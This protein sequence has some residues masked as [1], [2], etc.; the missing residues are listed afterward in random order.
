MGDMADVVRV[1]SHSIVDSRLKDWAR[2]YGGGRYVALGFSTGEHVLAKLIQFGGFLPGSSGPKGMT[3][4]TAADEVE[5]VVKR[6]ASGWPDHAR[7]LRCDYFRPDMAM[8]ARLDLLR[9]AGTKLGRA[10]YY[11]KLESAKLYVAGAL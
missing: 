2:E 8:P 3:A 6:L 1:L 7:V 4:L 9:S 11:T 5:R 10:G